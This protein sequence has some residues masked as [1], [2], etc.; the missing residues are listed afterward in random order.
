M[1]RL[2]V[3]ILSIA[4]T[5]LPSIAEASPKGTVTEAKLKSALAKNCTNLPSR[6]RYLKFKSRF[7]QE[8][9]GY[10]LDLSGTSF[11]AFAYWNDSDWRIDALN[12]QSRATLNAWEC[13]IPF[14]I[15]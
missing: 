3:L 8:Y 9:G 4:L 15:K 7:V 2:V 5:A 14:R 1:K 10:Y 13:R 6:F 11:T 12:T